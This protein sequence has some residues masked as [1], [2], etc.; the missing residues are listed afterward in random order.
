MED[1]A[2]RKEAGGGPEEDRF[3]GILGRSSTIRKVFDLISKVGATTSTILITGESGTGKE[4]VCRAIH[5]TS[6]RAAGPLIPVNCGAIP[7]EL[8]ESELFGH[9]KGAFTGATTSREGRFQMADGGTIFLDEV[10][11]M[12]PK[13]Q[14]KLLRV[15]QESE[16]ER[17][18]GNKTIRVDSR[19]VAAT[20]R[21]LEKNVAEG[22]FREDLYYRLNVIPVHLPPLRERKEDVPLLVHSFIRR[23]QEKDL[24]PLRTVHADAMTALAAYPWPGNVR[25]LENLVERMAI[26]GERPELRLEDLPERFR[27]S[28]AAG[29][30][31][32]DLSSLDIPEEGIDLREFMDRIENQLIERAL[33]MSGGVKNRAAQ[34]LGLNRTTLV[35]KLKK[36]NLEGAKLV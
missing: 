18:G 34:L 16:F 19:I 3:H 15:L 33:E 24:T 17:V 4:L 27:S 11:E 26:L 21:D 9:E 35:E 25:E 6:R 8:L 2:P 32:K 1:F 22:K 7:E 31:E 12:S 28:A 5:R 13:L 36:K 20:N 30:G 23:F 29:A 14:V 10:S